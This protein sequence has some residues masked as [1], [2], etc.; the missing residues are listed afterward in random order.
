MIDMLSVFFDR[1]SLG[2]IVGS[3]TTSSPESDSV[4]FPS[5]RSMLSVNESLL[6]LFELLV[7]LLIKFVKAVV[8]VFD[9]F[10]F[11]SGGGIGGAG[12]LFV[13]AG[14]LSLLLDGA[15]YS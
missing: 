7:E 14:F 4:L 9:E 8:V 2:R 1:T 13:A 12:T 10:Q 5:I 11:G 15:T 6:F 3:S